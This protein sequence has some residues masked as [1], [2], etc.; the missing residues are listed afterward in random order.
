M[1]G[2][3]S[4]LL[5]AGGTTLPPLFISYSKFIAANKLWLQ[6]GF[7]S[8]LSIKV[9]ISVRRKRA[10]EMG[11]PGAPVTT[12]DPPM[13]LRGSW[14]PEHDGVCFIFFIPSFFLLF[15]PCFSPLPH[16]CFTRHSSPGQRWVGGCLSSPP[17]AAL[18]RS[19]TE[20]HSACHL[21]VTNRCGLTLRDARGDSH[22]DVGDG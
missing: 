15:L 16:C 12:A 22:A 11:Q 20:P 7:K 19:H 4:P 2:G 8:L 1:A 10:V 21:S 6:K 17:P 14:A 5:P 9:E 18:T 3:A 13:G